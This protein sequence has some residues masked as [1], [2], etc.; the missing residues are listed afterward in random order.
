MASNSTSSPSTIASSISLPLS[1]S[2]TWRP[3]KVCTLHQPTYYC[4]LLLVVL[5]VGSKRFC[6]FVGCDD[7]REWKHGVGVSGL[8]WWWRWYC[9][10]WWL[11]IDFVQIVWWGF[12]AS[13]VICCWWES[14]VGGEHDHHWLL[15]A[16][17]DRVWSPQT[18]QG[19]SLH[20]KTIGFQ[21]SSFFNPKT[22][23]LSITLHLLE[24]EIDNSDRNASCDHVVRQRHGSH[25]QVNLLLN[26][27]GHI[28]ACN[29]YKLVTSYLLF[30][31]AI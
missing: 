19:S 29:C 12:L 3:S 18:N 15:H 28:D 10:F 23:I 7:G 30:Y 5:F 20:F 8:E 17:H 27:A 1:A 31:F 24:T 11:S 2:S 22:F 25:R 14:E 9:E 13:Y 21:V 16:R 6:V 26:L 4:S